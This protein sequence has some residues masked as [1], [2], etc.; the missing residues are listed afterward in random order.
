[1]SIELIDSWTGTILANASVFQKD[2]PNETIQAGQ[3][4]TGNGFI[5]SRADIYINKSG[6]DG[7]LTVK[8]YNSV[9]TFGV[10]SKPTSNPIAISDEVSVSS[11]SNGLQWVLFYFSGNNR[12]I[13]EKNKYY[14]LE[15]EYTTGTVGNRQIVQMSAYAGATHPGNY[16]F[17]RQST[18]WQSN[19]N[20]DFLF[21][22]WGENPFCFY[23]KDPNINDTQWSSCG[24][25]NST[26]WDTAGDFGECLLLEDGT[27]L[28]LED[29][30]CGIM[31]GTDQWGECV[32]PPKC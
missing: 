23:D 20:F 24:T 2:T 1:M 13:L 18:G 9:G 11:L 22:V 26:N 5:L 3:S 29:G 12:K 21:K 30:E 25:V 14:C 15:L 28:L 7:T 10:D 19:N 27:S 16:S 17:F 6:L 8:I 32:K 4:F 31:E